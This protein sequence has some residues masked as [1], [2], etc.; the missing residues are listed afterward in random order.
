MLED[1]AVHQAKAWKRAVMRH[2]GT[3]N[4]YTYEKGV[5][6]CRSWNPLK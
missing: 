6:A 1:G 2:K 5:T 4:E 3:I